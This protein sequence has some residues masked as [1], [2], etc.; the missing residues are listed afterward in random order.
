MLVIVKILFVGVVWR[1]SGCVY[2]GSARDIRY[3]LV[4]IRITYQRRVIMMMV[5]TMA[6]AEE[7]E[8]KGGVKRSPGMRSKQPLGRYVPNVPL[9]LGTRT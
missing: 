9:G 7:G 8:D 4:V 6:E 1:L 3:Q 2:C 5:A